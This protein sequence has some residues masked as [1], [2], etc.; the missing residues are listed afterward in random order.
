MRQ[1]KTLIIN[2]SG[3]GKNRQLFIRNTVVI[4]VNLCLKSFCEELSKV[5]HSR[6]D[7]PCK[8]DLSVQY[9]CLCPLCSKRDK[10][11]ILFCRHKFACNASSLLTAVPKWS[12]ELPNTT[13]NCHQVPKRACRLKYHLGKQTHRLH[14]ASWFL[15]ITFKSTGGNLLRHSTMGYHR[16][17]FTSSRGTHSFTSWIW[18]NTL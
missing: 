13:S 3:S 1:V 9:G 12:L 8:L 17:V 14:Y 7:L 15:I 2:Q 10:Q 5:K 4:N 16:F 6:K 11:S 18:G